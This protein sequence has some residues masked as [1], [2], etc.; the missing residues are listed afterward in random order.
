MFQ[1][2]NIIRL[3]LVAGLLMAWSCTAKR[4]TQSN[5]NSQPGATTRQTETAKSIET[6]K[7]QTEPGALKVGEASGSY[8]AKGETVTLK[9]AYAGRA[10]RFGE[11]SVVILLTDKEIPPEA[12]AEE[13]K[14]QT[15]L[16]D[17][18][19]RGLEYA[20]MKDGYWVRYHP[21]QYQESKSPSLKD[22]VIEN[23]IVKGS[24]EDKGGLT[25]GKYA[26]SVK[27]VAAISK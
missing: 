3:L 20:I 23:D 10:Q 24:D 13:I 26:R 9:Y 5:A 8:T 27:F 17:G 12:L 19:I 22:Y 2:T 6:A 11:E 16:L 21:G 14:D 4:S 7:P 18:K 25:D 1:P 15:M